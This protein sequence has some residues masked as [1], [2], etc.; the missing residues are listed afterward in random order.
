LAPY[1]F[2]GLIALSRPLLPANP[3]EPWLTIFL[4]VLLAAI[5]G[6]IP[7]GIVAFL[8]W[9]WLPG[10]SAKS[11]RIAFAAAPLGLLAIVLA[12]NSLRFMWRE[13]LLV[14]YAYVA[15]FLFAERVLRRV[16]F[17][18][19]DSINGPTIQAS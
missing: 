4:F 6:T 13:A 10:K 16:G 2:G 15:L 9:I 17:V 5:V 19:D 3:S 8:L 7:Y 11:V 14:S 1:A 12:F 18:R